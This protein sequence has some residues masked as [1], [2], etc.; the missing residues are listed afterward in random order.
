[1]RA[2]LT[3]PAG[4]FACLPTGGF[5][6]GGRDKA[7]RLYSYDPATRRVEGPV[8]T[9]AGHTGM[10]SSLSLSARGELISGAWDGHA[11]VWDADAGR[12]LQV[13]E[14]HENATTALGLP[15]GDIAVGS[16][17]RKNEFDMPADFKL[18]IWGAAVATAGATGSGSGPRP[19]YVQKRTIEDHAGALRDLALLPGGAGFVTASNDGTA[20][21]RGFDGAPLDG[22]PR[23]ANPDSAD[24]HP[25][26][27]YAAHATPAGHIVT[28][29]D[30]ATARIF[31]ADGSLVDLL[32]LPGTPWRAAS[33]SN[34]DLVLATDQA[35]RSSRGHVYVFSSAPERAASPEV[36]ARWVRDIAPVPRAAPS[37][38]AGGGG[39]AGGGDQ[40]QTSGS[41]ADRAS[42]PGGRDGQNGFF[43]H[44]EGTMYCTWSAALGA[45][46][47]VGILQDGP[48]G[49]P[50]AAPEGGRAAPGGR[51]WDYSRAVT[52]DTGS[53]STRSLQL[54]WNEGDDVM[55]VAKDFLMRNRLGEDNYEEV[56][57]FIFKVQAAEGEAV[58]RKKGGAGAGGAALVPAKPQYV[59][60][61]A[62]DFKKV[63]PKLLEVGRAQA[64]PAG[65]A[66][67]AAAAGPG[68]APTAE[69][70]AALR[71]VVD[72][73]EQTSRFHATTVPRAGVRAMLRLLR[74]WPPREAFPL[75]DVL[76]VLVVHMDGALAVAEVF[77]A[78]L[79][80]LLLGAVRATAAA[81][82]ARPA[83]L[84]AA[85]AL[86]NCFRNEP[87]RRLVAGAGDAAQAELQDAV[88]ALLAHEHAT[89]RYAGAVVLHNLALS[90]RFAAEAARA[91]AAG[92]GAG[93]A[94][95]ERIVQSL[96][97]ISAG[98][99]AER[100]EADLLQLL[101]LAA[102]AVLRA[103]VGAVARA[104]ELGLPAQV[105]AVAKAGGASA[106]LAKEVASM[107]A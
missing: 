63:W 94:S 45:W 50:P 80:P 31:A 44:P 43:V 89:V 79:L 62:V 73:L 56:R 36:V 106:P 1:V 35:G 51:G 19:V 23:M 68:A 11:R 13:L 65:A 15:T 72:V 39:G 49:A 52:M 25:I 70:E 26:F 53:G 75:L 83:T 105:A 84:L 27:C 97:L 60:L 10:V 82:E 90:Q 17:G 64:Q 81:P 61:A 102:A 87:T 67:A 14:G 104:K 93:A 18:R 20:R 71:A 92:A 85:R 41:Y 69:E 86:F 88:G 6:T 98:L 4:L 37:D 33:L 2:L 16:S 91:G 78:T 66:T 5:A 8:R 28:C 95:A 99:S 58:R 34:G 9:L 96:A 107:L 38:D 46:Q 24:G 7:V 40:I 55:S 47:D 101:L 77:G 54:E 30:D 57:D 21:C 59:D 22:A 3:L 32:Q 100:P 76:R 12:C 42:R 103:D 29:S 48:E 74:A